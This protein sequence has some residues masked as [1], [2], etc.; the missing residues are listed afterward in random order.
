MLIAIA[1]FGAVFTSC[2][3]LRGIQQRALNGKEIASW[4][5]M[6]L[7]WLATVTLHIE[8][9]ISLRSIAGST[10]LPIPLFP[11]EIWV[12]SNNEYGRAAYFEVTRD[13]ADVILQNSG[14]EM[15]EVKPGDAVDY[16]YSLTPLVKT[17]PAEKSTYP[18]G[19][20]IHRM[21]KRD[22]SN[23]WTMLISKSTGQVWFSYEW[24][25]FSGN[26]P[27]STLTAEAI[28]WSILEPAAEPLDE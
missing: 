11:N 25:D 20:N 15:I 28:S 13:E 16:P 1:I 23:L 14:F 18:E 8:P 19:G 7:Y 3:L 4:A 24:P 9:Y 6:A 10:D 5:F 26:A 21:Q 2:Y 17:L 22:G 27:Q 12:E